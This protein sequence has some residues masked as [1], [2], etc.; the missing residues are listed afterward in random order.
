MVISIWVVV[1]SSLTLDFT[2]WMSLVGYM[3]IGI[4]V[5]V[6]MESYRKKN[7]GKMDAI[8]LTPDNIKEVLGT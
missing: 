2:G 8:I 1:A 5:L 6:A 4:V 7:P 3:V